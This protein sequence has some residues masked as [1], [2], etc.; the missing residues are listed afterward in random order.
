MTDFSKIID[1]WFSESARSKW[2]R[3]TPEFDAALKER[4]EPLWETARAG[5]QRAGRI[6]QRELLRW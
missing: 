3:S 4:Y 6:T 1:F 2:F 5:E